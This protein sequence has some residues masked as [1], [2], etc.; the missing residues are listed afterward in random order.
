MDSQKCDVVLVHAGELGR[1]E[2]AEGE[3]A[4]WPHADRVSARLLPSY[5]K[6]RFEVL[7]I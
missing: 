5:K 3:D 6:E 4:Q 2:F 1:V 7:Y